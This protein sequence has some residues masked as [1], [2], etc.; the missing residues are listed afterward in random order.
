MSQHHPH[1]AVI[2]ILPSFVQGGNELATSPAD[3]LHS[4]ASFLLAPLLGVDNPFPIPGS[5][6]S[7]AD[8]ARCHVR[9][10]DEHLLPLQPG[11]ER[12]FMATG[13]SVEGIRWADAVDIVKREFPDAVKRGLLPLGGRQETKKVRFDSSTTERVLGIRF[14]GY[15]EQVKDTV[16]CCLRLMQRKGKGGGG[17]GKGEGGARL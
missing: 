3:L 5:T 12:R 14:E 10:L 4:S 15:E 9:A 6:V 17:K 1:Y 13:P 8:V 11:E 7:N 16:A 2:N